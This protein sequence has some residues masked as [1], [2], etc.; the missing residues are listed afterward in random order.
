[1][2]GRCTKI[3][4]QLALV[5]ASW[6]GEYDD[7]GHLIQTNVVDAEPPLEKHDVVDGL[8]VGLSRRQKSLRH[9]LA[10]HDFI[11]MNLIDE[12]SNVFLNDLGP[13]G[14]IIDVATCNR[15]CVASINVTFISDDGK[16]YTV[17]IED[18]PMMLD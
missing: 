2:A 8:F 10:G 13:T 7:Q 9:P 17:R 14:S 3:R 15:G 6:Y 12:G 11:N 18:S 4:R 16:T 1:M 5:I